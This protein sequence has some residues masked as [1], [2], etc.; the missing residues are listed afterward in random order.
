M[1]IADKLLVVADNIP[2]VYEAGRKAGGD[3]DI[4]YNE[5]YDKGYADGETIG[6]NNGIANAP[7]P[8]EYATYTTSMFKNAIFPENYELTLNLPNVTII[9]TMFQNAKNIVKATIKGNTNENIL[10]CASAF[11]GTSL[12]T[13]DLTEFCMKVKNAHNLFGNSMVLQEIKG[14][15]DL[16]ES[17]AN[18]S[19]AYTCFELKEIRFKANSIK[20]S[21]SFSHSSKLSAESVQSIIDG[22]AIVE[23]A[24]TL[25]L[26]SAIVLTDE[27]KSTIESKGWT[28]VQ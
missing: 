27:Q 19:I 15:I 16:T 28:L 21:I 4:A 1:S 24:Q 13:I 18:T 25:T 23:T 26:N 8:L 11:A 3:Y 12:V 7:N 14:I 9:G 2:K 17:T 22:L 6:Y 5:G 20:L 10:D